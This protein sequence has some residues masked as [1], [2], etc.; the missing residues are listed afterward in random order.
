MITINRCNSQSPC[1]YTCEEALDYRGKYTDEK[2]KCASNGSTFVEI[3]T[4]NV[5]CFDAETR[6]WIAW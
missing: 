3:D 2:P 4:G 1:E 5:F 6:T